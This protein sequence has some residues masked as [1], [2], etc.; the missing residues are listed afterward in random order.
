MADVGILNGPPTRLLTG[1]QPKGVWL[2]DQQDGNGDAHPKAGIAGP[3]EAV[4]T[5]DGALGLSRW[6]S[7]FFC[8]LDGPRS[9][10]R[11][12]CTVLNDR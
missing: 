12:L 11:V 6:Q 7:I 3:S 4:P 2:H 5:V 9:E 1:H 10:R 8:E